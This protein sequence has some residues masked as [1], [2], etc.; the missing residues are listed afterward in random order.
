VT[1]GTLPLAPVPAPLAAPSPP[2]AP[3]TVRL[4]SITKLALRLSRPPP[5]H[6]PFAN[7]SPERQ[8]LMGLDGAHTAAWADA[9]VAFPSLTHL[10][11]DTGAVC[12]DA[13]GQLPTTAPRLRELLLPARLVPAAGVAGRL[14]MLGRL[15]G[16][17][18]L[19]VGWKAAGDEGPP[20]APGLQGAAAFED[21]FCKPP[22]LCTSAGSAP[23][24]AAAAAA[25]SLP[26]PAAT[27]AAPTP[28]LQQRKRRAADIDSG[29]A[30]AAA[31]EAATAA[32]R[33]MTLG[34]SQSQPLDAAATQAAAPDGC[35][36]PAAKAPRT[37]RTASPAAAQPAA[38]GA[39]AGKQQLPRGSRPDGDGLVDDVNASG[40]APARRDQRQQQQQ[41][42]QHGKLVPNFPALC[43]LEVSGPAH[44]DQIAALAALPPH[45]TELTVSDN[46]SWSSGLTP[47]ALLIA[48][49]ARGLRTGRLAVRRCQGLDGRVLQAALL[50]QVAS[51]TNAEHEA[52]ASTVP[53]T[54]AAAARARRAA[55]AAALAAA[56]A[57][58]ADVSTSALSVDFEFEAAPSSPRPRAPTGPPALAVF[59]PHAPPPGQHH[60]PPGPGLAD[61]MWLQQQ[62]GGGPFGGAEGGLLLGDQGEEE[63]AGGGGGGLGGPFGAW[64]LPPGPAFVQHQP[65]N[66]M[67]QLIAAPPPPQMFVNAGG[68]VDGGG[69]AAAADAGG[70]GFWQAAHQNLLMMFL[71]GGAGP[72]A[73]GVNGAP[74]PAA[75]PQ[76]VP[77][78]EAPPPPAQ[79]LADADEVPLQPFGAEEE[80]DAWA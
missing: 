63:E 77:V 10:S 56:A 51:D 53:S 60:Q 59:G 13:L 45:V 40:S 65:A 78:A 22:H 37:A 44:F 16:L 64:V 58:R 54:A 79:W 28:S 69:G 68:G 23:T 25:S 29:S 36:Q 31:A 46:P 50:R 34:S 32:T 48:A 66:L 27:S 11:L 72:A 6:A 55:S 5:D 70:A 73:A 80:D 47:S 14:G 67:Q 8:R 39:H 17:T 20:V 21:I 35:P 38:C 2:P 4:P 76:A 24:E 57:A 15:T 41:Q 9:L 74:P 61:M 26:A 42:Q 43:S 7:P 71:G 30:A 49:S 52:S 75:A 12:G 1:L 19:R 62:E 33:R 3:P 18:R